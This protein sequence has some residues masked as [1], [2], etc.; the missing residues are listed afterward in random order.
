MD[1]GIWKGECLVNV[2]TKER[3]NNCLKENGLSDTCAL[4]NLH[5]TANYIC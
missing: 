2:L 4:K 5:L 1:L 3:S